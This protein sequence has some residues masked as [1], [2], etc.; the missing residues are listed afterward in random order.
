MSVTIK[1]VETRRELKEFILFQEKLYKDDPMYVPALISDEWNCLRKDR[2]P[3]FE[4]CDADYFL[5]YKDGVPAGRIAAII[6]NKANSDWNEKTARF[7]WI[8]MIDDIE[9]TRALLET[10]EAWGREKGCTQIKG[11]LGFTDMDKEGLLVDG[12]DKLPSITVI[13]NKPYYGEHLEALGYSKAVDWTQKLIHIQDEVPPVL[14]LADRIEEK[15]KLKY[16][17][18]QTDKELA[19]RG[20]DLFH[21]LNAAFS[22]LFEFTPLTERQID[23][24]VKQYMPLLNR[25]LIGI[26][27]TE[28]DE[29]AAFAI[30]IPSLSKAMQKARGRLFPFGW[31]HIL[32][33]LFK[34]DEA[35]ALMIGVVPKYQGTGAMLVMVRHLYES[36]SK[37]GIKKMYM[38]PMLE[39]NIKVQTAFEY[40]NPEYYMRRRCY[41]K[42]L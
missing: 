36:V 19:A 10:V 37:F 1:K 40:M 39:E 2:N 8:D 26:V 34:N 9:V 15:F 30:V 33:A 35:D 31:I 41:I 14:K 11:P 18:P 23:V 3:A 5:A 6:N 12:F 42:N 13:Y 16:F 32:K 27:L 24:Y 29:L 20:R 38:N 28:D 25:K 17:R 4:F 22:P 7:G 21:T